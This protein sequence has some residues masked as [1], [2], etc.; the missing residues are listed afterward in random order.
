MTTLA[1]CKDCKHCTNCYN[2]YCE[3]CCFGSKFEKAQVYITTSLGGRSGGK[4]MFEKLIN[5]SIYNDCF[6]KPFVMEPSRKPL[7]KIKKVIHNNPCTIV[8]WDDD[9]KTIVRCQS[10]ELYDEEKGLAMAISKKAL[11]NKGNYFDEFK[12]WLPKI[13]EKN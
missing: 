1:C 4:T 2:P 12:K 8:I 9:T 5:S 3:S 6:I 13:E 11:G 7:P 10:G